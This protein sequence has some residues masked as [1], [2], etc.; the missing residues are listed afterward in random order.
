M[1]YERANFMDQNSLDVQY[2][3]TKNSHT[4]DYCFTERN[5]DTGDFNFVRRD[6]S[7]GSSLFKIIETLDYIEKNKKKNKR[8]I[9]SDICNQYYDE[10]FF[11]TFLYYHYLSALILDDVYTNLLMLRNFLKICSEDSKYCSMDYLIVLTSCHFIKIPPLKQLIGFELPKRE[12]SNFYSEDNLKIIFKSY[13]KNRRDSAII[14]SCDY[15][16]ILD[17]CIASLQCIFNEGYIIRKCKNC[18]KYFIPTTRSDEIYCD[19]VFKGNRT[20]KQIGYEQKINNDEFM[21]AYRTAY[22]TK[23]A[24]KNRNK[25]NNTHAEENFE[26]WVIQAKE[27]LKYAQNGNILIDDFKEWLKS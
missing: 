17:L 7:L 4:E 5:Q 10:E 14:Y 22:K 8:K 26:K 23:N 11:N 16:N 2:S 19:N 18:G 9:V 3:H 21:K 24:F 12:F 27:K 20:C 25:L 1:S 13:E 15:T 6:Y